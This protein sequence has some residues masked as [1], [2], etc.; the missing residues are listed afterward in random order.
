MHPFYFGT[1]H[2]VKGKTFKAV[3]LLLGK[4]SVRKNYETILNLDEKDRNSNDMEELRIVYVALSRPEL[5]L[6]MVVPDSD[7]E[8]WTNKLIN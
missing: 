5:L 2:S 7:V 3:L 4:K 1:V 8:L 6:K